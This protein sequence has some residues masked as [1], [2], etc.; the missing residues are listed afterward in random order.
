MEQKVQRFP[1][2]PLPQNMHSLPHHQ[3]P[4]Q[5]GMLVTIDG[6]TST[7]HHHLKSMVYLR[8]H[9]WCYTFCGVGQVQS[10]M[11]PFFMYSE[12]IHCP[13]NPVCFVYKSLCLPQSL[14]IPFYCVQNVIWLELY[15]V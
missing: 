3:D 7:H 9:S 4:H 14:A 2:Y 12:K 1:I 11:Y 5:N 10:Y 15:R 13:K 6:H 8:I